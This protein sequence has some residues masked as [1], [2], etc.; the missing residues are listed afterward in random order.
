[1]KHIS[2]GM[3]ESYITACFHSSIDK[4]D[5]TGRAT[6]PWPWRCHTRRLG[7]RFKQDYAL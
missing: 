5:W 7:C 6:M 4:K 2:L 1:M 3:L